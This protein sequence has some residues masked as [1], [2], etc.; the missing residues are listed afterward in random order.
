MALR[1]AL[2]LA[3]VGALSLGLSLLVD[4]APAW[5]SV[6]GMVMASGM[7]IA[8][9][10]FG[11]IAH[12][13]MWLQGMRQ[14][15]VHPNMRRTLLLTNKVPFLGVVRWWLHI[16]IDGGDLDGV[17]CDASLETKVT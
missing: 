17:S 1:I 2:P 10:Q 3:I 4:A 15:D 14:S 11:R 9:L 5:R 12:R 6:P 7:M 16:D 13:W 8:F